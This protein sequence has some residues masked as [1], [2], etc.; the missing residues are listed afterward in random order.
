[1]SFFFVQNPNKTLQNFSE[2]FVVLRLFVCLPAL[3]VLEDFGGPEFV[4]L[5]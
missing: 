5:S 1:M 2:M 3:E 4:H